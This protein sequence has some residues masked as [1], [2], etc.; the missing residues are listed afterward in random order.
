MAGHLRLGALD[1]ELGAVGCV[2]G[3]QLLLLPDLGG[4]RR[5]KAF[6]LKLGGDAVR[7]VGDRLGFAFARLLEPCGL[8]VA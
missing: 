3:D 8:L 2:I 7:D 1:D 5:D 6:F 4:Q